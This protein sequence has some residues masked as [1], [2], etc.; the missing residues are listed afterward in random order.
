MD[1][2]IGI[3]IILLMA[4]VG[5]GVLI[6]W[7]GSG[8]RRLATRRLTL[9]GLIILAAIAI[10]FPEMT[11]DIAKVL[12]VGRGADLLLYG[13]VVFFIGYVIAARADRSR[14]HQQLTEL[15]RAQAIASAPPPVILD[16]K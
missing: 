16:N 3:K 1:S 12:G 5:V 8:A 2:Q 14:M 9:L 13:M 15:A 4:T 6:I 10:V 11:S 7:P